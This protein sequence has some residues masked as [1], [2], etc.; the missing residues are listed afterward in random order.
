MKKGS[1]IIEFGKLLTRKTK[2]LIDVQT[3]WCI[4]KKVDWDKK[5]M[6]ATGVVDD[7]DFYDVLLGLGSINRK[8]SVDSK[9]LIGIVN[10]NSAAAFLIECESVDEV[11][12]SDAMGFKLLLKEGV[13]TIN[14]ETLG[15]IVNAIE[16]KTQLDKNTAV[17]EAIKLAFQSWI[18]VPNDGGAALK[19]LS[20]AFTGLPTAD[21]SNIQNDK[22]KHG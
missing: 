7:L 6:T 4:V 3:H 22:I 15:G 19:G 2:D 5:T 11:E 13:L 16:L 9:C 20:S 10:N 17:L 14:G 21:L 8:P 12:I 18:P 1:N